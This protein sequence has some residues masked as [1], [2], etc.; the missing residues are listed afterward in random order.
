MMQHRLIVIVALTLAGMI[1]TGPSALAQTSFVDV[2]VGYQWVDVTGNED[3]YRTQLNQDDGFVINELSVSLID[4][5]GDVGLF[6]RLRIDA[7]GFG[8][9][10]AGRFRLTSD[11]GDLYRFT[12]QAQHYDHFSALPGWANPFVADGITPGQ[13]TWDRTRQMYDLEFQLFPGRIVTP[14]IGYRYNTIEDP[15]RTTYHVGQDEFELTSDVEETEEEFRVGLAFETG[16]WRGVVIQ[17]W[18]DFESTGRSTL[19]AGAGGGNNS[20]PV[21]GT[22]VTADSIDRTVTTEADTPV[23]SAYVSGGFGNRVRLDVSYVRADWEGDTLSDEAVVGSLVSFRI[24]RFFSALDQSIS[25]RTENPSWRGAVQLGI[26]LSSKVALDLSYERRDRELEGWA[27][28]S[29]L[30]LETLNFSGADPRDISELAE[31]H[32]GYQREDDIAELRLRVS[33]LGPVFLWAEGAALSSSLDLSQD[34]AQIVVPGGQF[35]SFDRD[36]D[37]YELGAGIDIG[38][39]RVL[40]DY[41]TEDADDAVVRTD[42]LDRSRMRGRIDWSPTS[43]LR[44]LGTAEAIEADNDTPG[45]GY[46]AETDHWAVDLDISATEDLTFRLAWDRYETESE[47]LIRMPQDLSLAT[48]FH[49]E[50]GELLEGGIQWRIS[51]FELWASYSTLENEGSLP[52]ELKRGFGRISYDFDDHWGVAAEYETNEYVEQNLALADFDAERYGLFIRWR[53]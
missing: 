43:W 36:I 10:P 4:S 35:G 18:R 26:D 53:N 33:D 21:L 5:E 25:S 12:L 41:R 11:L 23:T 50:D 42:F 3:M 30:Y 49:S 37:R 14:I 15:R 29:N 51:S 44:L 46:D 9:S 52:F 24:G 7:S 8:G 38:N 16:S 47:T 48:S 31:I 39:L 17:G 22:D 27:L 2:E 6:D 32:N 20:T 19:S 1:V 40:V 13:H 34:V 45:I 28:I